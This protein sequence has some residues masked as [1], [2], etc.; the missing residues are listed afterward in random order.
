MN[1][2]KLK[3]QLF[4][5]IFKFFSII[6]RILIEI[7]NILHIATCLGDRRPAPFYK[8]RSERLHARALIM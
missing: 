6:A 5:A 2:L 7:C 3:N 1:K 4:E 8:K